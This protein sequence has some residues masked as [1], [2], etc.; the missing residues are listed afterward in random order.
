[1]EITQNTVKSG[2]KIHALIAVK[3]YTD[4]S[5]PEGLTANGNPDYPYTVQMALTACRKTL[6]IS[7]IGDHGEITC[8]NCR[9]VK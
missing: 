8:G 4:Y 1:M 2:R 3:E 5:R 9:R 7:G 6:S